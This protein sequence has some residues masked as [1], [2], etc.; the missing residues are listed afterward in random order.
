VWNRPRWWSDASCRGRG[1]DRWFAR[2]ATSA[3][4]LALVVCAGCP[5]AEPCLAYAVEHGLVGVWGG[6]TREDRKVAA[7]ERRRR[8]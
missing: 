3:E 7:R 2:P 6:T 1:T 4:Q 8:E 5:V